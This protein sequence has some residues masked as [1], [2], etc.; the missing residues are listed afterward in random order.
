MSEE[1]PPALPR[2]KTRQPFAPIQS[3]LTNN[4]GKLFLLA[5]LMSACAAASAYMALV[6][7]MPWT[8]MRVVGPAIGAGWFGLRIFMN[9]TPRI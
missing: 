9:L 3:P 8:D 2:V 4:A 6:Q 7:H 1:R 5:L